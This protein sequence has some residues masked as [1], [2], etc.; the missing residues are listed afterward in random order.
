MVLVHQKLHLHLR[1][2]LFDKRKIVLLFLKEGRFE[3]EIFLFIRLVKALE[4]FLHFVA[5]YTGWLLYL[6]KNGIGE[7]A[8]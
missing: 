7:N 8:I 5:I 2:V 1:L 4:V 6:V 3:K